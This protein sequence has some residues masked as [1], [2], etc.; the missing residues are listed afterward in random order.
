[1]SNSVKTKYY[2]WK[3]SNTS[4]LVINKYGI[5][6]GKKPGTV[7]ITCSYLTRSGK[8]CK[9]TSSVTVV[10]TNDIK[11]SYSVDFDEALAVNSHY[12]T[13]NTNELSNRFNVLNLTV[14]NNSSDTIIFNNYVAFGLT[15]TSLSFNF[16][17]VDQ[18]KVMIPSHSTKIIKFIPGYYYDI[19]DNKC[20]YNFCLNKRDLESLHF[21]FKTNGNSVYASY[22]VDSGRLLLK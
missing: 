20:P 10:E 19:I 12:E 6:T 9:T 1:M 17:T 11:V 5:A 14:S 15:S 18:K 13:Y 7:K 8:W 21:S 3:S 4:K 16:Q 22:F 2:K